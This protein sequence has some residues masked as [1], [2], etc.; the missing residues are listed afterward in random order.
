MAAPTA[1]D[2]YDI[3][4]SEA[5]MRRPSM[6][7]RPGDVSD[8]VLWGAAVIGDRLVGYTADRFK[9]TYVDGA[10]QADLTTLADDHWSIVRLDAAKASGTL[11]F[12]RPG[13]PGSVF[14][15]ATGTVVATQRDALG[16][17]VR[18]ATLAPLS[19]GSGV[20]GSQ[21]VSAEAETG[22]RAGN[23]A[24]ATITRVVTTLT[25]A[26]TVT[27]AAA[28]TG[29]SAEETDAELRERIR[30]FPATIRRGT[31]AALEYGALQVA[32]VKRSRAVEDSTGAVNLYVTDIDGNST[33]AMVAAVVVEI[34]EW[35]A[36][37]SLVT[38]VGGLLLEVDV[39]VA[40]TVR[41]GVAVASLL[42]NVTQAVESRMTKYTIG[43]VVYRSAIQAAI[44]NVD[45]YNILEATVTMRT[46]ANPYAA[47]DIAPEADEIPRAG[48]IAVV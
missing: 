20:G 24:A 21:N 31:L 39:Q 23:V 27:N 22:G 16:N 8:M 46:G 44:R 48:A 4:L 3:G 29:G 40:L 36:A 9:A 37:G 35:R 15:L 5:L 1:Q 42:A 47:V 28:F 38:I 2:L 18:Y 14:N 13:T 19:W 6:A 32:A 17:E 25:E 10:R 45:P 11:T 34:E 26:I 41:S 30:L 7:F 12:T 33:A 43:E